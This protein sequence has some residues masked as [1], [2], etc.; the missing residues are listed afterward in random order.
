[1]TPAHY[2]LL[3]DLTVLVH[4][5]FVLF[6]IL[7]GALVL[8]QPRFAWL[9]LPAVAWGVWVEL[10]G[11]VCPLTPLENAWRAQSGSVT[12][13]GGFIE[14]YVTAALYPAGLSRGVQLALGLGLLALNLGLYAWAWRRHR[15]R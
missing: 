7:G 12:Y 9:H 14:H 13:A 8:R 4:A 1:M 11:A 2:A 3:A 5:G 15:G 10:Y 6:V